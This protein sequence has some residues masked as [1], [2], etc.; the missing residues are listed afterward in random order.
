MIFFLIS[1]KGCSVSLSGFGNSDPD[2]MTAWIYING[3]RIVHTPI[4]H[5]IPSLFMVTLNMTYT[6]CEVMASVVY[7]TFSSASARQEA[8]DFLNELP[9]GTLVIGVSADT[10][11][12]TT[13]GQNLAAFYD[14]TTVYGVDL[15]NV[16]YRGSIAFIAVKDSPEKAFVH[17]SLEEDGPAHIAK[18]LRPFHEEGEYLVLQNRFFSFCF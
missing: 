3:Q 11:T 12:S 17:Q 1:D 6:T 7:D 8:V 15:A 9:S 2:G 18:V 5:D 10:L 4:T 13:L 16:P 14:I